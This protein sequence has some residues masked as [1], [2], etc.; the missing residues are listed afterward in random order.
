MV[1]LICYWTLPLAFSRFG[2]L[3]PSGDAKLE[4]WTFGGRCGSKVGKLGTS[5]FNLLE[6]DLPSSSLLVLFFAVFYS[7]DECQVPWMPWYGLLRS[8]VA[9]SYHNDGETTSPPKNYTSHR[10]GRILH[11][12]KR[13][14]Q[15][16]G[17]A[18]V[19]P[20]PVLWGC[21]WHLVPVRRM[22]V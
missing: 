22:N 14:N 1:A 20:A 16:A 18:D 19:C 9:F 3:F 15:E 21:T 7:S 8:I 13:I 11:N 10:C 5:I 12:K 17:V 4:S 6:G 2:T